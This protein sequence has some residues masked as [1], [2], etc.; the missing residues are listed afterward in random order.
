MPQEF[1]LEDGSTVELSSGDTVYDSKLD[2]N[3]TVAEVQR[4]GSIVWDS[5][6]TEGFNSVQGNFNRGSYEVA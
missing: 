4:D 3:K 6:I 2:E 5:G 1:D